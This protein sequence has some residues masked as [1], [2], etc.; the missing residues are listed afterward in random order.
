MIG[1]GAMIMKTGGT[2]GFKSTAEWNISATTLRLF[3]FSVISYLPF[4]LK[5]PFAIKYETSKNCME[6]IIIES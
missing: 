6:C 3:S 4:L 1:K 2:H 5:V